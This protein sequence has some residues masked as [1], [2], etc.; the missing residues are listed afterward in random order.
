M[1]VEPREYWVPEGLYYE[2]ADN[3]ITTYP[4]QAA[5]RLYGQ[6]DIEKLQQKVKLYEEALENC[7]KPGTYH[8][9][10]LCQGC[11]VKVQDWGNYVARQAL[12]NQNSKQ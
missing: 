1:M 3:C 2:S 11:Q 10:G 4:E 5:T 8:M 12:A 9:T 7:A 6:V